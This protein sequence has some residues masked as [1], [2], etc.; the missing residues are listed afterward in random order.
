MT[1][2]PL[3]KEEWYSKRDDRTIRVDGA[4]G[5]EHYSVGVIIGDSVRSDYSLQVLALTAVNILA[6]WCRQITIEMPSNV[7]SQLP[8]SRGEDYC[9]LLKDV[10]EM[11]DPYNDFSFD[12]VS[13]ESVDRVLAVG[14]PERRFHSD[15]V[16]ADGAGWLSGVRLGREPL[17]LPASLDANPVGPAFSACLAVA[18]IFRL[19]CG[20]SSPEPHTDWYSLWN[21]D[22]LED[23]P[24]GHHGFPH[25]RELD[26]GLIYQIGCGA[27]GS[28]LDF[29]LSMSEL[30]GNILLIDYD[31][32]SVTDCNRSM[33]FGACDGLLGKS[34]ILV[35]E[36]AFESTR[37]VPHH[38]EGDYSTY[39]AT[40]QYLKNPPDAVLCLANEYNVW[41][42]IQQNFP[43]IVLHATTTINWGL[44][45]GRHLPKLDWCILC[46]FRD[47]VRA[48]FRP[49]CAEGTITTTE[50][51]DRPIVGVLPFLSPAAAVLVLAELI[52]VASGK[53]S[54]CNF[55]QHS[56]RSHSTGFMK[57]LRSPDPRCIC[58][59]QSLSVYPD[60][61]K[62]TK[63]WYLPTS[64]KKGE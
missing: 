7:N 56:M 11:A 44:N 14:S 34:K 62:K 29:L 4:K 57:M 30:Q 45:L 31:K 22:L 51:S 42:T 39:I 26:L 60:Q 23:A 6:R 8:T 38:F 3:T 48:T 25:V 2:F 32:C 50:S 16:F 19:A 55:M 18:E 36:K 64:T 43:P 59:S 37:V 41:E 20:T 46:R 40:G 33:I 10:T 53:L 35:C 27:V 52:R 24:S 47:E 17:D 9:K 13:E 54:S 5:F 21:C 15:Q 61:I 1:D 12:V 63:F 58:A 28:C 49:P